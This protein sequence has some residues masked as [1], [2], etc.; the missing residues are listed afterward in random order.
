M[1]VGS[2]E[3]SY[4]D[5]LSA[6]PVVKVGSEPPTQSSSTGGSATSQYRTARRSSDAAGAGGEVAPKDGQRIVLAAVLFPSRG[7]D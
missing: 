6:Q 1:F 4:G 5:A 7:I 2:V 3:A